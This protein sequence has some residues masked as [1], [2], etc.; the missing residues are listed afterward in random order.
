MN[1]NHLESKPS[2]EDQRGVGFR[3]ERSK[4]QFKEE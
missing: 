4:V 2:H 1:P 3:I